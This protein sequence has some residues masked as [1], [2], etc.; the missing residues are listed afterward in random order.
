MKNTYLLAFLLTCFQG[1]SQISSEQFPVFSSC[2]NQHDEGLK[3]CFDLQLQQY[4]FENFKSKIN[5]YK[6]FVNV[7]FEV[8][9]SGKFKILYID[10]A[11]EDLK[12][13][14]TRVFE[15]LPIIKPATF[16]G[17]AIYQKFSLKIA[18]PIITPN[19]VSEPVF[20]SNLNQN[21]N[22]NSLE[23]DQIVNEK[24]DN[25]IFKSHLNIPFSHSNY[26]LFDQAMSQV[27]SNSHT[28]SK[29]F[30]Y[31][32]VNRNFDLQKNNQKLLKN[33]SGWWKRKIFDEN[34]FQVQGDGYWFTINPVF[35]L[36]VGKTNL[37]DIS[38][39]FQNT[40]GVFVQGALGDQLVFSSTIY[41]SQGR[42]ADY[43]NQYASSIKPSGGDPAIIPGVGIAKDFKN[44]GFDF[45]LAEANLSFTANRF[46]NLQLGYSRNF[47]GDGYRSLLTS[48]AASPYPFFKINTTFWKIKYTNT[49]MWL[50]DVRP[51]VTVE[52]TYATKY[53]A[54][55][56]LSWNVS[57]QLNI[58]FFESVVW[59]NTNNRGFDLNFV[60]PIIFYRAV[61]FGSSARSGN[62]VLGL[63]SKFKWNNKLHFY[64]QFILDEFSLSEIKAQNQSWKNKYGYQLGVKYFDAFGQKNLTLQ[65]EY[66]QV[67]PYVYSHSDPITN[68]AHNNQSLGHAW[69]GNFGELLAIV[70]Y[71]KD[72]YYID[73][74][75]TYGIRGFDFDTPE[76]GFN[77]GGNIYKPYDENRPYDTG[78]SIGQGNK[79][80]VL[81][82]DLQAGYLINPTTNLKLF[83]SFLYRKYSPTIQTATVFDSTTT[84]FSIGIR[85]DLF[86][87]YLDY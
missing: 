47:L 40:R 65:F 68:Y 24:F 46:V 48:D 54:N 82:A 78:V 1:F 14:T 51:E 18:I 16:N 39:T 56:Y 15:S 33:K 6:G 30:Q 84:W 72:R 36:Q 28:G 64:G 53:I 61:E 80:K 17:K 71:K 81:I 38:T 10:T 76:D 49:Y 19:Q 57:N 69:G 67:R 55:H 83:G 42:F 7:L 87:F 31:V 11:F 29:P 35:D 43:F 2:E 22:Q 23:L 3:N 45:P 73:S 74:K 21:L 13:E 60:N 32:D 75:C 79:T 63:T 12:I 70:R 20:V 9:A 34:L 59:A 77:Y 66:N 44:N 85:T 58:G 62:A 50:K 37:G 4:I 86:N 26:A 27:G 41:E 52:R 5:D 25:P 8:E